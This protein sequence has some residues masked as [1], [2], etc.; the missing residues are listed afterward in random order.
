MDKKLPVHERR[1]MSEGKEIPMAISDKEQQFLTMISNIPGVIYRCF[2]DEGFVIDFISDPIESFTGYPP[3][4]FI[5]N[6]VRSYTSIIH[7]EDREK[8]RQT[9]YKSIE[10]KEPFTIEYRIVNAEGG[11]RWVVETG[12]GFFGDGEELLWIDGAVFDITQQKQMEQA[13]RKSQERYR[14]L[15]ENVQEW[16]WET[17]VRDTYQY[18]SPNVFLLLG[19]KPEEILGKSP[20]E[21]MFED[22]MNRNSRLVN[23]PF[24]GLEDRFRHKDG[25]QVFMETG[26]IPFFDMEGNFL[27]YR[28]VSRDITD[29]KIAEEERLQKEKL[30]AVLETAGA[31]CHEMNQPLTSVFLYI[32]LLSDDIDQSSPLHNDITVIKQNLEKMGDITKRLMHITVYKTQ[33]YIQG[34]K[35]IDIRESS[36][37]KL[38]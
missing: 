20:G 19:Y 38:E 32:K 7:T 25:H 12:R 15:V 27:G 35:I 16:I 9:I 14:N 21:F 26:G 2:I 5:H 1:Q 18:T 24:T 29:R 22:D 17:D 34:Q 10:K 13:L 33:E 3:S 28:G 36:S 4:D 37:K 6:R 30:R 11:F 8:V 23:R 31:V